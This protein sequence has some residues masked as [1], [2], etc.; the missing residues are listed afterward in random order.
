MKSM[1]VNWRT[2]GAAFLLLIP[3]LRM[4]L[5]DFDGDPSTVCDWNVVVAEIAVFLGLVNTRDAQVTSEK[6][7]AH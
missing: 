4:I 2:S 6:S 3:T 1:L 7:G 5:A